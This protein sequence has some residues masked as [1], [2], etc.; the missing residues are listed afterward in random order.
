MMSVNVVYPDD[1]DYSSVSKYVPEC[2]WAGET[3]SETIN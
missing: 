2:L 3:E 1:S